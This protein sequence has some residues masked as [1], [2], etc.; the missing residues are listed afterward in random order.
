[1][2][3]KI[4]LFSLILLF[5]NFLFPQEMSKD[6]YKISGDTITLHNVRIQFLSPT[7]VRLEYSPANSFTNS[8]T[9]VVTNRVWKQTKINA[10]KNEGWVV[11]STSIFT[12]KYL[13]NS[14]EFTN[15]NLMISW[16]NP[17]G[18]NNWSPGD[19][20][21]EN[22]GGIQS[23]LDGISKDKL[24]GFSLGILSRS[25]YFLL[26]D[27]NSPVWDKQ[28]SWIEPRKGKET[29]DW[30]FFVYGNDYKHVLKEYSELCGKI[31]MIPRYILGSWITDLNYEYLPESSLIKDYKYNSDNI[32]NE[33]L[34][35]RKNGIPLDIMVLDFGWH[36]Y[37]WQGG[38]DWS[39]V[40]P[41][42]KEFLDW[43]KRQGI[44]V[45]LNDHPGYSH[46][47][48]L[49]DKDSHAVE[50][51]KDLN[52]PIPPKPKI[53]IDIKKDWKFAI[54]PKDIGL[55]NEWYSTK[56]DDSKW[57]TIQAGNK[58][59]NQGFPD[60]DGYAWYR[61][62][63]LIPKNINADSLYLI[64]GGVDDMYDLFVNGKKIA[65]FGSPGNGVYSTLTYKQ[66][67]SILNRGKENLIVLRVY[68][69]G[70]GGGIRRLPVEIADRIPDRGIHF[71]LAEKHQAEVFMK[72]LHDP[73]INE[74]V[75]FWWIDG[76]SGSCDMAGLNNQ[77]WANR[78]FYDFTQQD[79]KDRTFVFSR[80]GGWGNHRYP[81]MFTGDTFS[82][83]A[84]LNYEVP[85]TARGGNVLMPYITHDI[86]GFHD[87]KIDFD[88]YARWI[89]FGAFSPILRL[90]SAH[91]NPQ[92]GNLRMPWTYGQKGIDLVKKFFRL[93]YKLIPYI[94]T[95]SRIAHDDALPLLRPLYLEYPDLDKAYKYPNEYFFGKEL[96]VAPITNPDNE[97]N[98]YLPPGKWYN[99]FTGEKFQGDKVITR[100]YALDEIP[101]FVK[102]GSVIPSRPVES[103][104]GEKPLDSLN[105]DIYA[106][107]SGRFDL[108]NDDGTSLDYKSGSFAWTPINFTKNSDGGEIEIGPA[109]GTFKG[110]VENR[111]YIIRLHDYQKPNLIEVNGKS[112][113]NEI[114]KPEYWQWD[115]QSSTLNMVINGQKIKNDLK[116]ILR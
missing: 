80:Y 71:N 66:V 102:A 110:Q 27:S 3:Y 52:M 88:L 69:W 23:S 93:R 106:S 105:V 76:G 8:S 24:P 86:G 113:T 65:H 92:E 4:I 59:E 58:W 83:W 72:V 94:Y 12:L 70:D 107:E 62:S 32:K 9:A 77:M 19:S 56:F 14:G 68:D 79:T 73:L 82:Q 87:A 104:I 91:E 114:D 13:I 5:G 7:L 25:G 89:E 30:Y 45:T 44:K 74:G 22:L 51:R 1:M 48:V 57:K 39:P 78:V 2:F 15:K 103:F 112:I 49:S 41:H 115:V 55:S 17:D 116:I 54:D 61:K 81:G 85:F 47:S 64:F 53:L 38:Y 98:V 111:T 6:N 35:F 101:I 20:D 28:A 40:F 34:R 97:A 18:E 29:Q 96:L 42:S 60:Y 43:A 67:S 63:V 50:V 31:P 46:E 21:K 10:E 100:K 99:Y 95:Y 108:Y 109:K 16:Q 36:N 26:D 37:G 75:S 33:I 90:H 84:V 11:V